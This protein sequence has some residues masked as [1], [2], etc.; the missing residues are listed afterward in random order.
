MKLGGERCQARGAGVLE[1]LPDESPICPR[2]LQQGAPGFD[3]ARHRG[4]LA[5]AFP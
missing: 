3:L 5:H 4:R 2:H 1:A